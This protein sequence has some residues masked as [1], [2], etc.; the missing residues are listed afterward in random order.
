MIHGAMDNFV[1]KKEKQNCKFDL[2][3]YFQFQIWSPNNLNNKFGFYFVKWC[4]VGPPDYN[5]RLTLTSD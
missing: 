2:P 4:N 3:I 5:W 1:S